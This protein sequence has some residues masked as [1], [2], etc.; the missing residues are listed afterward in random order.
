MDAKRLVLI[1]QERHHGGLSTD[2]SGGMEIR[3]YFESTAFT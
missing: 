2:G 1:T 3:E